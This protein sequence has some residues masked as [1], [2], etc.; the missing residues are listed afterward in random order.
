MIESEFYKS[1]EILGKL[2]KRINNLKK[3]LSENMKVYTELKKQ[4]RYYTTVNELV[5]VNGRFIPKSEQRPMA[6]IHT[7]VMFED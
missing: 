2:E 5:E 4:C 6:T 3:D 7:E 1:I